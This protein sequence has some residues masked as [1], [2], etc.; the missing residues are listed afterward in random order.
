[1]AKLDVFN[2]KREKVSSVELDDA[3]FSAP[4]NEGLFYEAVKMHTANKRA[5]TAS[6]KTRGM[7][8]GGGKKPFRQ[9]G[10]GR[11]RAGSSRSPLWRGG[12][13]TF[14]PLPRDYSYRMPKKA[15]KA[16][17]RSALSMKVRD[18][19]LVVLE[20]LKF[21]GPK[22][23]EFAKVMGTFEM[24]KVLVIDEKGNENLFKSARNIRYVKFLP[25]E[26][27]NVYDMLRYDHI[28]TTVAAIR[29]IEGALKK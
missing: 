14:G 21:T 11:A 28:L 3:V 16:A 17:L 1:M 8:R 29:K 24:K 22:T 12:A 10:T 2:M 20:D 15:R 13:V 4:V 5:G 6:T 18:G 7:V 19:Q 27:L 23:K 25:E 9:K 26:G